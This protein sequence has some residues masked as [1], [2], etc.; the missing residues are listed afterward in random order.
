M[1]TLIMYQPSVT[2]TAHYQSAPMEKSVQVGKSPHLTEVLACANG[3]TEHIEMPAPTN[4]RAD[5]RMDLL[6]CRV[7]S[8]YY[9]LPVMEVREVVRLPA[10]LILAGAPACCCGMLY[11]RGTHVPIIDSHILLDEPPHY[12]LTSQIVIIGRD[13]PEVGLLVEEVC[14]VL[15]TTMNHWAHFQVDTVSP[16]L[17]GIVTHDNAN[18]IVF[19]VEALKQLVVPEACEEAA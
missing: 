2:Q 3:G 19:D 16:V 6:T 14:E 1:N 7:G 15:V 5:R 13:K 17:R 4:A 9:G 10:L 8:Q 18:I 12:S 11:L